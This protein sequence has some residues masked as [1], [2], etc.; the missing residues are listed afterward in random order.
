MRVGCHWR[1]GQCCFAANVDRRVRR[2]S[3]GWVKLASRQKLIERAG[4]I[5]NGALERSLKAPYRWLRSATGYDAS[6]TQAQT[7]ASARG[8][9]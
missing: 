4:P 2:Q 6:A 3:C 1:P 7:W 8:T 9:P 5:N